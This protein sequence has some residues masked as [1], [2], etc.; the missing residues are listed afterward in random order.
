[1]SFLRKNV[2]IFYTLI[3]NVNE[4]EYENETILLFSFYKYNQ[5]PSDVFIRGKIQKI[6]AVRRNF[7]QKQKTKTK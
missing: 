2:K 4:N 6:Q 3:A 7:V 1:M 5:Y